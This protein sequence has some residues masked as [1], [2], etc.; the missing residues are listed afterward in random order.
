MMMMAAV[1]RKVRRIADAC[2]DVRADDADNADS[3]DRGT[4][5]LTEKAGSSI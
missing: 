3:G 2:G 1:L 4:V 5:W